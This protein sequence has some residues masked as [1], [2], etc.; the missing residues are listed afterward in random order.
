MKLFIVWVDYDGTKIERFNLRPV[1]LTGKAII[2]KE[3]K[4]ELRK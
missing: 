4:K 2:P 1:E 3:A